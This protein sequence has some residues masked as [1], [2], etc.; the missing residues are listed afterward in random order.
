[1]R[2]Q[3]GWLIGMQSKRW[4]KPAQVDF[5]ETLAQLISVGYDLEKALVS[6]Q[7]LLP[8]LRPDLQVIVAGLR[9]GRY[10][11]Q[12]V[13][14]YVRS[15]IRRELAFA[16][17][18]GNLMEILAEI[19]SRER[20]RMRQIQKLRQLLMYPIVLFGLLA[21][22]FAVFVQ[23]LLPEF[24]NMGMALPTFVGLPVVLSIV[25]VTLIGIAVT[26]IVWWRR[27]SWLQKLVVLRRLPLVGPV[28]RLSLDYQISLQ[29]GLLLTSGVS[30]S[31]IVKRFAG[32][33]EGGVL[34]EVSQLA[35]RSLTAG[36]SIAEFVTKVPLLPRESELLFSK[37]KQ[38]QEIGQ[39]FQL[40]AERKF[41]LLERQ[42]GRYLLII[43]PLCFGVIGL[44]V[45]G[46]YLLMLMPMYQNMGDLMTW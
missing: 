32:L 30:F 21:V 18:H 41:D 15:E 44:V 43:Q 19:G 39:E 25:A 36:E 26:G 27:H 14:P 17:V 23:F 45:V 46:L 3:K 7:S 11:Y 1:M 28:I 40:L 37:G 31:V 16:V 42:I 20:R 33:E 24:T 38:Q 22:I 2:W 10:F 35:E 12:L 9:E 13:T 6:L 4:S 29:L 34:K 8:K 5:F